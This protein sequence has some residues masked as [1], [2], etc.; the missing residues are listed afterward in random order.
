MVEIR[1]TTESLAGETE[2][3]IN[4]YRERVTQ[5]LEREYHQLREIAERES[6]SIIANAYQ[7]G[8]GITAKARQQAQQ[9]IEEAKK[10]VNQEATEIIAKASKEAEQ[11]IA[12]AEETAKKE[13]I[14]KKRLEVQR[15]Q[16]EAWEE[17]RNVVT[18]ARA[19]AEKMAQ[20]IIEES[21]KEAERI[22]ND[23]RDKERK[24]AKN[25][26]SRIIAEAKTKAQS[27]RNR[28]LASVINETKRRAE[29]EAAQVVDEANRKAQEIV[30]GVRSKVQSE[31]EDSAR[32]FSEIK[33]KLGQ[34]VDLVEIPSEMPED[35]SQLASGEVAHEV[36]EK[37]DQ[38][39][40]NPEPGTADA[41]LTGEDDEENYQ[42][43]LELTALPPVEIYELA[44][45]EK[46]LLKFPQLKIVSKGG[47]SDGKSWVR[48]EI[49][50]P[51]PL[52]RLLKE[53]PLVK[54][55]F[56]LDNNVYVVLNNKQL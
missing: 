20:K 13:A 15:I 28:V 46:R 50:K 51:L 53:M 48:L 31:Y 52:V 56:V 11:I 29:V 44:S 35:Q 2:R 1:E 30:N 19:G 25:E 54:E 36:E 49:G 18:Q 47:S 32:L 42:G 45:L 24:E 16:Q 22:I 7:E 26:A 17:S 40:I 33:Q 23:A 21:R 43:T 9:I 55:A 5:S 12:R 37:K 8:E 41:T 38:S 34:V 14:E 4:E 39:A 3:I 10:Q 27:V 6:R